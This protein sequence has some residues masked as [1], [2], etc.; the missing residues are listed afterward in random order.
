MQNVSGQSYWRLRSDVV[1]TVLQDGGVILDLRS[2]FFYSANP[3]A[4]AIVQMFENGTTSAEVLE[5]SRKW[6][7][8]GDTPA[9]KQVIDLILS[10]GLVEPATPDSVTMPEVVV[11]TWVLPVLSKHNEPLQR[12]MVSAFDP[13][14]PLAE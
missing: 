7:A 9:V 13:G 14:M 6:G 2:K 11:T 5:A 1:T 8:N 3:T 4:L 10:E 12:I